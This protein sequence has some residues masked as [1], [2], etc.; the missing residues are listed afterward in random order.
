M[1]GRRL[2]ALVSVALLCGTSLASAQEAGDELFS[3]SVDGE[4]VA[5]TPSTP[6][7]NR[8]TDKALEAADIQVKYDGLNAKPF[9]NAATTSSR[10]SFAAGEEVEILASSNYPAYIARQEIRIFATGKHA[11]ASPT[12]TTAMGEAGACLPVAKIRISCRAI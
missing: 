7:P 10:R 2:M 12:F 6:D 4:H 3:I 1:K 9:L 5:G 8:K 11:P